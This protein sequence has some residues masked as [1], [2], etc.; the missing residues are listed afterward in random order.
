[1]LPIL[2]GDRL[3]GRIDPRYDRSERTLHLLAVH[4]EPGTAATEGERAARAIGELATWLGAER[5]LVHGEP[6]S[7]WRAPLLQRGMVAA[8]S[9]VAEASS[10]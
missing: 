4:A 10:R 5:V 6:P 1:M 7:R 3:I 9:S 8:P 2:D